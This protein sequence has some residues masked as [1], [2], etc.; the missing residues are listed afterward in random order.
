MKA[1]RR[2]AARRVRAAAV[3]I[4]C[5]LMST[6]LWAL[7]RV[8]KAKALNYPKTPVEATRAHVTLVETYTMPT[9][10]VAPDAK[11]RTSRVRYANRAG[12]SPSVFM[13]NGEVLCTNTSGKTVE[14]LSLAVIL[15]DAFHQP[16]QMTGRA[17]APDVQQI[18]E[19]LSRGG[20][21]RI[22]WEQQVRS[23]EVY[24]IAVVVTRIRFADGTTWIAPPEELLDTF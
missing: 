15:L 24:E 3:F 23:T 1:S 7:Q 8:L 6:S 19:T 14:A 12:L 11:A 17:G 16:I 2:V 5:A 18:M 4:G 9:Q 13:L 20:S 10:Y 22:T 21:K